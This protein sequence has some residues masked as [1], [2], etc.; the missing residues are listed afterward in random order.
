MGEGENGRM[1]EWEKSVLA[2]ST[3]IRLERMKISN[4][5]VNYL[6]LGLKN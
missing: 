1:G 3:F 6:F 2:F 4:Y 5:V